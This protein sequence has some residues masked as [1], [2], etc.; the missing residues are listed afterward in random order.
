[1]G[2]SFQSIR[3][4]V[5]LACDAHGMTAEIWVIIPMTGLRDWLMILLTLVV[6]CV[7]FLKRWVK[8]LVVIPYWVLSLLT[9]LGGWVGLR[10]DRMELRSGL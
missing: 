6:I 5:G 2:L 4:K 8:D 1:M 3:S 10:C 7:V 9:E